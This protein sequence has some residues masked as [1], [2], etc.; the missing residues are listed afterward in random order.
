M[1]GA[2]ETWR[3]RHADGSTD[4]ATV[5][6]L[7]DGMWRAQTAKGISWSVNPTPRAAVA[8]LFDVSPGDVFGP[9][10]T[11]EER[12]A[13]ARGVEAM[14]AA[15]VAV[16]RSGADSAVAEIAKCQGWDERGMAIVSAI[17]ACAGDLEQRIVGVTIEPEATK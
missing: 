1:S 4:V 11:P 2:S 12:A 8:D 17:E 9:G 16:C 3:V 5:T 6:R 7:D 15:A 13:F 10:E 14:R